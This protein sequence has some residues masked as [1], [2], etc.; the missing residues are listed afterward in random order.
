MTM[1]QGWVVAG[2]MLAAGTAQA[3]DA[4][5][6]DP[7]TTRLVYKLAGAGQADVR[8]DQRFDSG[9]VALAF[10]AYLPAA[11][12]ER[13][14]VI[15]FVSGASEVRGWAWYQDL[16]RL[17]AAHGFVG[18]VPDKRYPRGPEGLRT[19]MAD[20]EALIAH[21]RTRAP[22]LGM[23]PDRICL[24][25]FSAGGRIAALSFREGA[26]KLACLIAYYPIL[27]AADLV[28][29]AERAAFSPA[30]AV[31]RPGAP[32]IPTLVARA[33][34]DSPQINE[35]I[36]AYVAAALAAGQPLTLINAPA[37]DHGFD[38]FN[39]TDESRLVVAESFRFAAGAART[40]D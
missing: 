24:W 9:G 17:A 8:K 15:V 10:D 38:G 6:R 33:G 23:D 29:E 27:S 26:P 19:G 40:R 37:S 18:I 14:P 34:R 20:T 36:D 39:D 7:A 30:H 11:K 3:Q 4:P 21:L 25:V 5:R 16:G 31:A 32:R 2:L 35:T 28:P 22:E 12:G 13:R 1:R